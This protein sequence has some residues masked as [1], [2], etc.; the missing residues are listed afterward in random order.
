MASITFNLV[1]FLDN[2]DFARYFVKYL[3]SRDFARLFI[4]KGFNPMSIIKQDYKELYYNFI[5]QR[6]KYYPLI[7]SFH[8]RCHDIDTLS[9]YL[10][11]ETIKNLKLNQPMVYIPDQMHNFN[12]HDKKIREILYQCFSLYLSN[13]IQ[14][15]DKDGAISFDE[16][17]SIMY[18]P[19][20][21][22]D[23]NGKWKSDRILRSN[24]DRTSS[25]RYN[26]DG[27][28]DY[29]GIYDE[30]GY[31]LTGAFD[32]LEINSLFILLHKF[33][34]KLKNKL[35]VDCIVIS[36]FEQEIQVDDLC[37]DIRSDVLYPH[38]M[39]SFYGNIEENLNLIMQVHN[40]QFY[41]LI[42][43]IPTGI[44]SK[45]IEESN[46]IDNYVI[47]LL[48]NDAKMYGHLLLDDTDFHGRMNMNNLVSYVIGDIKYREHLNTYNTAHLLDYIDW[49]VA[50]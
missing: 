9:E 48:G 1:R 33:D 34:I 24:S 7:F 47:Y 27:D 8:F 23:T 14:I 26:S 50:I 37:E 45:F 2:A 17:G 13:P 39:N 28:V 32:E 5:S 41:S 12:P 3:P 25:I 38:Y 15:V 44:S 35:I 46:M 11:N 20:A 40:M 30:G 29:L 19:D 21:Y 18:Y 10:A 22:I 43:A 42:A 4:C 16:V 31:F 6:E 49:S 36:P